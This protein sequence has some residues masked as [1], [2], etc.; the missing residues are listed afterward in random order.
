MAFVTSFGV[1]LTENELGARPSVI[2]SAS[3]EGGA[4]RLA[5]RLPDTVILFSNPVTIPD[6]AI[7][8]GEAAFNRFWLIMV[9]LFFNTA[10][11]PKE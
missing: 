5:T 6:I 1:R 7:L 2:A 9:L 8:S 4:E 3:V 10:L 11:L